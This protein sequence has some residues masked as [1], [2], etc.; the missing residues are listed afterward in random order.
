[1]TAQEY[2]FKKLN[3]LLETFPSFV[4]KY[5]L[6]KSDNTHII[7]VEPLEEYEENKVY[8]EAESDFVFD[9]EN[10]YLPETIMFVSS[11]SLILVTEPDMVFSSNKTGFVQTNL[12]T[13]SYKYNSSWGIFETEQTEQELA[14]AA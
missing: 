3:A 2:I 6:D 11:N 14:L 5:K 10:N 9:F 12:I 8:M 7:S 13:T 4:F 1:M